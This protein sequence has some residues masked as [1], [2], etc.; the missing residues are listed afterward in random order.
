MMAHLHNT[1][2]NDMDKILAKGWLGIQELLKK[3]AHQV[4]QLAMNKLQ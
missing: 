2:G 4:T 3:F 1:E